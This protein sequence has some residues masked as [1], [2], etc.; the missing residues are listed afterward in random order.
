[1]S[2]TDLEALFSRLSDEELAARVASGSLTDEARQLAV[3]ELGER[4][5]P[6]PEAVVD[7]DA[8]AAEA[9]PEVYLG[10]MVL[11]ERSLTPTE[12][13]LLCSCL[14][15]A[16]IHADAGDTNLVQANSLL[17][18]AVGGANVRVPSTQLA[19]ARE[20]VAAFRRGEFDLGD[21]FEPGNMAG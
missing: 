17:S 14:Q 21:D 6:V 19:E 12:A 11:L 7:A 3:A 13:H 18:I 16:G 10:D 4:G 20:V 2:D 1:M 15:S 5:L 8:A 9:V